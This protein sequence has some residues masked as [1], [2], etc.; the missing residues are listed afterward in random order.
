ME[1]GILNVKSSV[2]DLVSVLIAK[3]CS[4]SSLPGTSWMAAGSDVDRKGNRKEKMWVWPRNRWDLVAVG[5]KEWREECYIKNASSLT[6]YSHEKCENKKNIIFVSLCFLRACLGILLVIQKTALCSV[7]TS[8][9]HVI[10]DKPGVKANTLE[11]IRKTD[12]VA[13]LKS[14]E[15]VFPKNKKGH[16]FSPL[17][18][19]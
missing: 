12:N 15:S 4:F 3:S 9:Q 2:R 14:G 11:F 19:L 8:T 17:M 13:V 1:Y 5:W 10:T 6:M 16:C 18:C 7:N